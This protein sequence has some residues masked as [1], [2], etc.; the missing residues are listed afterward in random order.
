MNSTA[1][2]IAMPA[3]AVATRG[4]VL[5]VDDEPNVLRALNWLLQKDFDVVTAGSGEE[6]LR[7]VR[8]LNF[9]VVV[10]DQRMPEMS[11]VDFLSQVKAIEPRSMRILLTG[12][13]DLQ[14]ILHSVNDSEIFRYV[15]KP[16]DVSELPKVIAQ[17]AAIA[18]LQAAPLSDPAPLDDDALAA[19]GARILLIDDDPEVLAQAR[20][21]VGNTLPIT[22]A[23]S[24]LD[25]VHE[26]R[27]G[28]VS[29]ILANT[30]I[31]ALD[32]TRLIRLLKQRYPAIVTVVLADD[33][34]ANLVS[35]LINQGQ[36]FRFL[37]KPI[38]TSHLENI[39]R[40]A[41]AKHVQLKQD[42]SQSRRHEVEEM[43]AIE[44]TELAQD[45]AVL[46][47][48]EGHADA[49]VSSTDDER[50]GGFRN[51][52]RILFGKP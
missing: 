47:A 10:S 30:R 23:T 43:G 11:G 14:S 42:P 38:Q 50:T 46:S 19:S 18:R 40:A 22:H 44:A 6:G 24:L 29:V 45:L 32:S 37:A 5:C 27:K 49:R 31:G 9:D 25:A 13:S 20:L 39:L 48:A 52:F 33:T 28:Q 51:V 2:S 34:G 1:I 16:W 35:L 21:A 17:A 4:R 15:T 8:E 12:Y 26:L 41:V 3:S 7:L 36:V